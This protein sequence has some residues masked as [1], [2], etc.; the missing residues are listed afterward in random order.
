MLKLETLQLM[1]MI[2]ALVLLDTRDK[3]SN[4]YIVDRDK[5]DV[6][7]GGEP[8]ILTP[9]DLDKFQVLTL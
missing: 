4:T 8:L 7:L 6:T 9:V 1:L 5:V 3:Q 2:A